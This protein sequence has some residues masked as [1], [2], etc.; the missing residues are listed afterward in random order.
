MRKIPYRNKPRPAGTYTTYRET[1]K[2]DLDYVR[3][4]LQKIVDR[5]DMCRQSRNPD[6]VKVSEELNR[7]NR[8]MPGRSRAHG[9]GPNSAR[10]M[11]E[12]VL[13]NFK[14]GQFDISHRQMPGI[15]EA[16]NTASD[17][18]NDIDPVVFEEV[19][20]LP[21]TASTVKTESQSNTTFDSIFEIHMIQPMIIGVRQIRDK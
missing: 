1:T 14:Q 7:P 5:D 9:G 12:G 15:Q 11:A 13:D 4:S 19:A 20:R 3:D 16:I 2:E 21:S 6:L 18:F 8:A 17:L 10:S